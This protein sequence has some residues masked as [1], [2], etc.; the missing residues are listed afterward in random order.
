MGKISKAEKE[1]IR[2]KAS[3]EANRC[4]GELSLGSEPIS[5]IF[6][7]IERQNILLLRYPSKSNNLSALLAQDEDGLP[8]IYINTNMPLGRQ[9]FSAAHEFAH[10][11]YHLKDKDLW[12]CDPGNIQ[13]EDREEIF[14]D[15]FA[16][17]FLLPPEGV[18]RV[19]YEMFRFTKK[20]DPYIVIRMQHVFNV[21]YGAMLYAL[22]NCKI[23]DGRTY[24]NLRKLSHP[25]QAGELEKLTIGLGFE[26]VLMKP[27]GPVVPSRLLH[28]LQKNYS[29][30]KVSYNKV[31][32]ILAEW[33]KKPADYGIEY[34]Y[35]I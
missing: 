17:A 13:P 32:A 33:G 25:D 10:Y 16:G 20:V 14:A 5:D 35:G 12:I 15:S 3:Y 9:V 22:Y 29:E 23:I 6:S 24:G 4:R 28:A 26:P 19:F 2:E 34:D 18:R 21:S 27:S 11:K 8:L 30:E 1:E 7:M 31:A